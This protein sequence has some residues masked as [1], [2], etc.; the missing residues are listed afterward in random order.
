[1]IG[2]SGYYQGKERPLKNKHDPY[3]YEQF[4]KAIVHVVINCAATYE[5]IGDQ[6]GV[7]AVRIAQIAIKHG[8]RR[9][10]GP[11]PRPQQDDSAAENFL[12]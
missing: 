6:F 11:R 9:A 5:D 4:E 7:S 3:L 10:R 1:V 8:V 2:E 12:S